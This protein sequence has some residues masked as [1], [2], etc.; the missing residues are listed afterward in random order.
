MA[1]VVSIAGAVMMSKSIP[2]KNEDIDIRAMK[3]LRICIKRGLKPFFSKSMTDQLYIE[4]EEQI[5]SN[6]PLYALLNH[7]ISTKED[8][9]IWTDIKGE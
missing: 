5:M 6:Q 4:I 2:E 9:W 3:A 8:Q 1:N 7:N